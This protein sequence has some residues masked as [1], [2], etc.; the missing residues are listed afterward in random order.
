MENGDTEWQPLTALS[1]WTHFSYGN[2]FKAGLFGG[3]MKNLGGK[4]GASFQQ[5]FA[6]GGENLDAMYRV[7][8]N[9]TYNIGNLNLGCEYELTSVAY[10]TLQP[11]GNVADS[12]WITN[13]RVLLSVMY[14]F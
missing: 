7:A 1:T 8:P 12:H 2:Q 13:H 6:I 10:G 5:I 9:V 14:N 3:Y 4:K 11:R